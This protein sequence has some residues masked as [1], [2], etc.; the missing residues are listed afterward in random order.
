MDPTERTIQILEEMRDSIKDIRDEA[1]Q[2]N[3]R[4]ERVENE[5]VATNARLDQTNARL[6]RQAAAIAGLE[7]AVVHELGATN[8]L[9]ERQAVAIAGLDGAVR[10]LGARIDNVFSGALGSTV[11]DLELRVTR[12]EQK[13]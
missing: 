9:L 1:R 7:S 12:L 8:A 3:V 11:R 10:G 5:S 6:D 13:T 2:T 4:L